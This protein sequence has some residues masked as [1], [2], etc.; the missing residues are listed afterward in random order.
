LQV[1]ERELGVGEPVLISWLSDMLAISCATRWEMGA[2]EATHG[3]ELP[4]AALSAPPVIL[5]GAAT[6]GAAI[7]PAS[8]TAAAAAAGRAQHLRPR[9][10]ARLTSAPAISPPLMRPHSGKTE[11]Q[12]VHCTSATARQG[13]MTLTMDSG[14]AVLNMTP[15]TKDE[16]G[17]Q[18]DAA[19]EKESSKEPTQNQP[20]GDRR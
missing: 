13:Q 15:G 20:Q 4:G 16:P 11:A 9:N 3:H 6:A 19:K 1:A 5:V 18:R 17:S 12:I 2:V 8:A 7:S 14:V 10:K